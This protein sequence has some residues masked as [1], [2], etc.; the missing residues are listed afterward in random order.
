M[1]SKLKISKLKNSKMRSEPTLINLSFALIN[2]QLRKKNNIGK[3][4]TW[5]PRIY[6]QI[7]KWLSKTEFLS[8]FMMK[9]FN[10]DHAKYREH[11]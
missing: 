8:D 1:G 3:I 5:I 6:A 7:L 10:L 9:Y 2:S 11:V 4:S